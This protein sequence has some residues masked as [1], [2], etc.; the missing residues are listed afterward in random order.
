MRRVVERFDL[1]PLLGRRVRGLSAG[2]K[3][4]LHIAVAVVGR[5]RLVLLDEATANLDTGTRM[6]VIE[7]I[8]ELAAEGCAIVYSS[9]YLD[10]VEDL[11]GRVLILHEGSA[12][13]DGPV[14]ELVSKF[15]GGRVEFEIGERLVAVD[16]S[17]LNVA[18]QSVVEV[19]QIRE[20]RVVRP[21][22]E[23]V[24]AALTGAHIDEHGFSRTVTQLEGERDGCETS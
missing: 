14:T 9:H 22:L 15:G 16:T 2:Q 13:A 21:S 3:R 19:G 7:A 23:A 6:V 8:R 18:L 12:I 17:D 11:C 10:E 20:A 5:P 24:F 4:L 1:G